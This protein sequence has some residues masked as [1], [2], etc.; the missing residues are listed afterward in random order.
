M[1]GSLRRAAAM[2]LCATSG[3]KRL[4]PSLLAV[5]APAWP[6]PTWPSTA[7]SGSAWWS[8]RPRPGRSCSASAAL[9]P[10]ARFVMCST[11]APQ[12]SAALEQRLAERG[13]LY[14]AAPISGGAAKAAS[15]DMTM[16]TAGVPA[17]YARRAAL[18]PMAAKGLPARW[19]RR[20]WQQG[21]DHQPAAGG[22]AYCRRGRSDGVRAARWRGC[23][24]AVRGDHQQ[25]GQHWMFENRM[26]HA[27]RRLHA[28]VGGGHL[29][30]RP[31]PGARHRARQQVSAAL[32]GHRAP[33]VHAGQHLPA[34]PRKATAR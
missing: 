33:D 10:G 32:V 4:P 12:W 30:P 29:R 21:R 26:A 31:R 14:L 23:G 7:T 20:Q 8:T 6:P 25:R 11:V 13:L 27:G 22:R 5:A 1:A 34:T 9:R 28:A 3:Q 18:D 17:A 24:G 19:P 15:G 2:C 16:M